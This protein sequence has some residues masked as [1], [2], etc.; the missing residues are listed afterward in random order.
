MNRAATVSESNSRVASWPYTN[1][2]RF[3]SQRAF[4]QIEEHTASP[5]LTAYVIAYVVLRA[6]SVNTH[7]IAEPEKRVTC[8]CSGRKFDGE[9]STNGARRRRIA[10]DFI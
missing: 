10:E 5:V 6:R 8:R 2:S 4:M 9:K 7:A 3:F 1:P